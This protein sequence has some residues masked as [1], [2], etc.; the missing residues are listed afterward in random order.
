MI[1][2]VYEIIAIVIILITD[3]LFFFNDIIDL[4]NQILSIHLQNK[5]TKNDYLDSCS[6][7]DNIITYFV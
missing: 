3:E 7:W 4:L 6:T 5:K 2:V 1:L